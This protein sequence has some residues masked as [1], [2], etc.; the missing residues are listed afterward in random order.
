MDWNVDSKPVQSLYLSKD[1]TR[2]MEV[3]NNFFATIYER[4]YIEDIGKKSAFKLNGTDEDRMGEQVKWMVMHRVRRFPKKLCEWTSVPYLFSPNFEL[5]IDIDFNQQEFIIR[6]TKNEKTYLRIPSDLI[7][8]CMPG[9]HRGEQ[10]KVLCS[11]ICWSDNRQL[12]IINKANLDCIFDI[13]EE[14]LKKGETE[15]KA[16]L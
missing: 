5:Q 1:T 3:V 12:R 11:R 4:I 2:L 7:S 13:V 6:R 16:R 8:A 10:V 15:P 14:P 9:G